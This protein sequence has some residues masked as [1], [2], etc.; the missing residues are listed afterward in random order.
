MLLRE[1]GDQ[2]RA[3]ERA[4]Q[5]VLPGSANVPSTMWSLLDFLALDLFP[6]HHLLEKM[7]MHPRTPTSPI[8]LLFYLTLVSKLVFKFSPSRIL[9]ASSIARVRS[10]TRLCLL[11]PIHII[12]VQEEHLQ[13]QS[14]LYKLRKTC[15]IP[16][17]IVYLYSLLLS[18]KESSV[19]A[20]PTAQIPYSFVAGVIV[21]FFSIFSSSSICI[22]SH[23]NT[24][25]RTPMA[26]APEAHLFPECILSLH[27]C[28]SVPKR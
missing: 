8:S 24:F 9:L 28:L 14:H 27:K 7:K 4:S 16:C 20:G 18:A 23:R 19:F 3:L 13:P 2:V 11:G 21:F 22:P 12:K 25:I 6:N 26:K 10:G 15:S 1:F 5:F 17:R